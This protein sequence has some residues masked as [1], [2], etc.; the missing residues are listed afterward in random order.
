MYILQIPAVPF[1]IVLVAQG[2]HPILFG[3]SPCRMPPPRLSLRVRLS[4]MPALHHIDDITYIA[5]M[6]LNGDRVGAL[7]LSLGYYLCS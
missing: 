6:F 2:E 5:F 4:L 1:H 7:G 3:D